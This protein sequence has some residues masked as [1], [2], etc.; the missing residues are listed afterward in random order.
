V[1]HTKTT[2]HRRRPFSQ[3]FA[4]GSGNFL[5][6][7]LISL[8][9]AIATA[10]LYGAHTIGEYALSYAPT[11]TVWY[12]STVQEQPALVRRLATLEPKT[13]QV[14]ALWLGVFAFSQALTTIVALLA[15]GIASLLFAGPLHQPELIAPACAALAGYAIL[16]NPGWNIDT[17]L[18]SFRAAPQLFA[19]RVHQAAMFLVIAVALSLV[20]KSVWGMISALVIS[21]GTALVHRVWVARHYL[22]LNISGGQLRQ[23]FAALPE[24][25]RFGVRVMPGAFAYGI[26]AE[27]GTW[28][29]GAAAS[30]STVG[31]WSRANT[32]SKRLSEANNRIADFLLPTIVE[33]QADGDAAGVDRAVIDSM[34]YI[35][36]GLLLPAAAAGGASGAVIALLFGK[37]YSS[38]D[39][40]LPFLLLVPVMLGITIFGSQA[41]IAFNRPLTTT[42]LEATRMLITVG[43]GTALALPWEAAGMGAGAAI[44]CATESIAVLLLIRRHLSTPLQKLW[45]PRA[46]TALLLA[47]AGGFLAAHY[48]EG[49]F[50]STLLSAPIAV[51]AGAAAYLAILVALRAVSDRDR[52]RARS[53]LSSVRSRAA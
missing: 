48:V 8:T 16:E 12:L 47:Y 14:T 45:P 42:A 4:F 5:V 38:A 15:A 49:A 44:A 51:A 32:I 30:V 22:T 39:G 2:P 53:L 43:L 3:A 1:P 11:G 28:I 19:V 25:L 50:S 23:G 35:A 34:R 21:Y 37:G 10:R 33:R 9:S 29:L 20:T 46:M 31:A 52:E 26:S 27:A 18:A 36:I 24:M 7:A 40:A 6:G 13:P 17:I 41:L